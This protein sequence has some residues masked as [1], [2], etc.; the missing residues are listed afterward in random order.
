MSVIN[1]DL[2]I[3][4]QYVQCPN[5][6]LMSTTYSLIYILYHSSATYCICSEHQE[7]TQVSVEN[8]NPAPTG[9]HV[10]TNIQTR[11]HIPFL[12]A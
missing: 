4:P 8:Q 3:F 6:T 1:K 10:Q 9:T 5:L 7:T 12:R 11:M 2:Y